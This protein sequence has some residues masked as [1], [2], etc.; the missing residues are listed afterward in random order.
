MTA[1]T[2]K[3]PRA[4][5]PKQDESVNGNGQSAPPTAKREMTL[6][7]MSLK[8]YRLT[9]ERLYGKRK[10]QGAKPPKSKLPHAA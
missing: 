4:A 5:K 2:T 7:E 3:T 1:K 9:H 8:A 6:E 10:V